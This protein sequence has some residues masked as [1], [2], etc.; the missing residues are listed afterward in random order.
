MGWLFVSQQRKYFGPN[1][2]RKY[3]GAIKEIKYYI[4][5]AYFGKNKNSDHSV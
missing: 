5:K 1:R 2:D 4:S 3:F